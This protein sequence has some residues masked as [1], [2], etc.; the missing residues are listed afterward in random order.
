MLLLKDKGKEV[1]SI[2]VA[3]TKMDEEK[4]WDKSGGKLCLLLILALTTPV[5]A[6]L[7]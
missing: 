4:Q 6:T 1:F 7:I 3:F 2:L 5:L